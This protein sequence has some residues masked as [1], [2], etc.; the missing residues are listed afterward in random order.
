M[1]LWTGFSICSEISPRISFALLKLCHK[2]NRKA[3]K[4]D[5]EKA[6]LMWADMIQLRK[7]FGTDTLLEVLGKK[8]QNKLLEIIDAWLSAN[9]LNFLEGRVLVQNNGLVFALIK[10]HGKIQRY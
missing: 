6:K 1:T 7:E 2:H 10:G 9:C 8:Y 3:R 5:L 4:F